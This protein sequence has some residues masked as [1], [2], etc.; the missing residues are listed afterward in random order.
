MGNIFVWYDSLN[1]WVL[2]GDL[3]ELLAEYTLLTNS[4]EVTETV[5]PLGR[6]VQVRSNDEKTAR[7]KT[8][9]Q[10]GEVIYTKIDHEGIFRRKRLFYRCFILTAVFNINPCQSDDPVDTKFDGK[11]YSDIVQQLEKDVLF[12]V[13]Q[14]DSHQQRVCAKT[15]EYVLPI[16]RTYPVLVGNN[17]FVISGASALKIPNSELNFSQ[18]STSQVTV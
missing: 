17:D 15:L 1:E 18:G 6:K 10:A 12:E 2:H 9:F 11:M 14:Q 7:Y 8:R 4:T 13:V 16:R 3:F 5:N